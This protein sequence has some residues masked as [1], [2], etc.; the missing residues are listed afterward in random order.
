MLATC[1]NENPLDW[2]T[3]VRKVCMAYNTSV[4]ASTGYAP[5]YLIFSRQ[6]RIPADVMFGTPLSTTESVHKSAVTL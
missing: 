2:E 6:A 1:T 4:Q 3:Y 5:F